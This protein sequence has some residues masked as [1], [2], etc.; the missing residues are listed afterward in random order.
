MKVH[1]GGT[2][3]GSPVPDPA[4]ARYGGDTTSFL[5]EGSSGHFLF[6]DAGTGLRN[7]SRQLAEA[8]YHGGVKLL[9]THTHLDH[10]EGAVQLPRM[11]PSGARVQVFSSRHLETGAV[12]ALQGLFQPPV[13]PVCFEEMGVKLQP[14][15]FDASGRAFLRHGS[16]A[17]RAIPTSHPGGSTAF[18]FDDDAGGSCVLATDV[19]WAEMGAGRE[20]AFL[21]FATTPAPPALLLFDGEYADEMYATRRGWGHSTWEQAVRVATQCDAGMLRILHHSAHLNDRKLRETD[22]AAG[23]RRGAALARQGEVLTLT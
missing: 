15:E 14:R 20:E 3:G 23:K 7:F 16:L 2:R 18:R 10:V 11:L 9:F 12:A 8:H 13:W 5:V 22:R 6:I 17:V 4:F 21:R 19:E 1:I